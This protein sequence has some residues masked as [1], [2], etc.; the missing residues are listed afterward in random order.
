MLLS[1]FLI[2]IFDQKIITCAESEA[3][4]LRPVHR[5][6][7]REEGGA[8]EGGILSILQREGWGCES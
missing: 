8:R 2:R 6:V 7:K 1:C 3:L 5:L 4:P